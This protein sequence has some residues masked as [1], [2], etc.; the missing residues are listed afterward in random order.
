[1]PG[2]ALRP[3]AV[4]DEPIYSSICILVVTTVAASVRPGGSGAA[5]AAADAPPPVGVDDSVE[6]DGKDDDDAEAKSGI[7]GA[8]DVRG[9]SPRSAGPMI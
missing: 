1:M 4:P 3:G 8:K 6:E 5:A 7:S 2:D 9:G